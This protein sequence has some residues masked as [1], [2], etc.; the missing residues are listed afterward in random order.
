MQGGRCAQLDI[1]AYGCVLR[2]HAAPRSAVPLTLQGQQ[3]SCGLQDNLHYAAGHMLGVP[4]SGLQVIPRLRLYDSSSSIVTQPL[5]NALANCTAGRSVL[6]GEPGAA[7]LVRLP[8]T[9]HLWA[10]H[11]QGLRAMVH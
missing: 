11:G 10:T 3:E 9:V 6:E 2:S 8:T 1:H 4:C 5:N 7:A